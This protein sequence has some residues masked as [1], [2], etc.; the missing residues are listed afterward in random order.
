MC[1]IYDEKQFNGLG[2]VSLKENDDVC[3]L[4]L[5]G[6]IRIKKFELFRN[7][8]IQRIYVLERILFFFVD[9]EE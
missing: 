2:V 4:E 5:D 9:E 3:E 7:G 6:D 8:C 1:K